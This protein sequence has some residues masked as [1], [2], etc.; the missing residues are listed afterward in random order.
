M[1]TKCMNENVIITAL[2]SIEKYLGESCRASTFQSQNDII[3]ALKGL[4]NAGH[5]VST[6]TLTNCYKVHFNLQ[7]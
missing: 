2:E 4:G 5:A 7:Y 1:N 3:L 6:K